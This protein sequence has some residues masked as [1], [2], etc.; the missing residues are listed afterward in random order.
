MSS[1][2]SPP[3]QADQKR[4]YTAAIELVDSGLD[5]CVH[6]F[7]EHH[8]SYAQLLTSATK[9]WHRVSY[10]ERDERIRQVDIFV[11]SSF[12]TAI[13]PESVLELAALDLFTLLRRHDITDPFIN[14]AGIKSR[15]QGE[16]YA[17]RTMEIGLFLRELM[18]LDG[19]KPSD[20]E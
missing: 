18:Q 3:E 1:H 16:Q 10:Q 11:F 5:H 19:L 9:K 6:Y 14:Y 7:E 8:G 2:G 20:F 15:A 12:L 13:P 17:D 4:V